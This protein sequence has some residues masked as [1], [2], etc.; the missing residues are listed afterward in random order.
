MGK[1]GIYLKNDFFAHGQL[2]VAMSRVQNPSDLKIFRPD[3]KDGK[4]QNYMRNVVYQEIL[5]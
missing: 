5:N 4:P 3:G 1:V 2:Y